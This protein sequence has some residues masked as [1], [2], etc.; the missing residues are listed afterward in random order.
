MGDF[1]TQNDIVAGLA[2]TA[3]NGGRHWYRKTSITTVTGNYYSSWAIPGL[4]VPPSTFPT[5]QAVPT[6][7]TQGALNVGMINAPAGGKLRLL[8]WGQI[9][10][11]A[12]NDALY[13]RCVHSGGLVTNVTTL[14][15]HA[16]D[17]TAANTAGLCALDGSDV[18]WFIEVY[19]AGGA[20]S[21]ATITIKYTDQGGTTNNTATITGAATFFPVSRLIPITALA[22]GDTSIKAIESIQLT[23]STGTAGNIGFCAL[24]RVTMP[25][26]SSGYFGP[27]MDYAQCGMGEIPPDACLQMVSF[28]GATTYGV[29]DGMIII[30]SHA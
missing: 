10:S 6:G 15:T 18:E 13:I 1:A 24:K 4:P 8:N 23:T 22:A 28:M 3:S 5:T 7:A 29:K 14:Q 30:G 9:V 2:G 27:Y 21:P 25:M 19:A 16:V 20:T 17:L 12:G 26:Y 11:V